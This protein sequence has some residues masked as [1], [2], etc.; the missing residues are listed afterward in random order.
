MIPGGA[1]H[2]TQM[3]PTQDWQGKIAL[4]TGASTG[5][6]AA[7]ARELAAHGL[8]VVLAA[9]RA[10]LLHRVKREINAAGGTAIAFPV[11]LSE[12]AERS[13]LFGF[14]YNQFGS[15]DILVNNAGFGWYGW[16]TDMSWETIHAMIR[17]NIDAFVHLTRL[18]LPDMKAK[19]SGHII[20][21]G[22]VVSGIPSQ[23]VGIYA[24]TKAFMDA[25]T[26]SL[27]RDLS[28]TN[29]HVSVIRPGPVRSEF[30]D[31]AQSQSN[32]GRIP[33]ERFSI[34]AEK[35]AERIWGLV[36]RPRRMVFVPAW[37]RVVPWVEIGFGWVMDRVG[38]LLL[39]KRSK[40]GVRP[41]GR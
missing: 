41:Q 27:Y 36:E 22:S 13:R 18:F 6:G 29:V 32:G 24:G 12:E 34:P 8:T 28:H 39:E 14:A 11:D 25:F 9:R 1:C 5:I 31:A 20:N 17:V 21:V 10:D 2:G 30:F 7:T 3:T 38:P 37:L 15:L 16:Y 26:T 35:V 23:G 33:A 40:P 4:V 19:N